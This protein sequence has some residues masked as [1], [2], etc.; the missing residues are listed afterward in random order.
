LRPQLP[1]SAGLL[2]RQLHLRVRRRPEPLRSGRGRSVL[3]RPTNR[4][5]Q[6]RFVRQRVRLRTS[7]LDGRVS[8]GVPRRTAP[9]RAGR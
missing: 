3:R 8:F 2:G 5:R 6:L 7:L 9:L 4:Q 1:R